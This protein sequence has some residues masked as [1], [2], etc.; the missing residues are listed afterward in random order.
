MGRSVCL[1][2]EKAAIDIERSQGPAHSAGSFFVSVVVL[3]YPHTYFFHNFGEK[4]G[5]GVYCRNMDPVRDRGRE[6]EEDKYMK[7]GRTILSVTQ[8]GKRVTATCL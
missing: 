1:G 8:N 6:R 5:V 4:V 7:I 2:P 3:I